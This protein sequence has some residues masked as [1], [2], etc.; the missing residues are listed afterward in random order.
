M[1]SFKKLALIGV[2]GL[3]AFSISCTELD[4]GGEFNPPFSVSAN[5]AQLSGTIIANEGATITAVTVTADGK[6]VQFNPALTVGGASIPLAGVEVNG[7]CKATGATTKKSFKI[8]V[9]VAFSEGEDIEGEGTTTVDCS[10]DA[11]PVDPDLIKKTVVLSRAGTSYADIDGE[12]K[13]YGQNDVAGSDAIMKS[14]D[15]VAYY[16]A[17]VSNTIYTL[18]GF[19][20]EETGETG[21][22]ALK[23]RYAALVDKPTGLIAPIPAVGVSLISSANKLSDLSGFMTEANINAIMADGDTEIAI[24]AVNSGFLV[25]TSDKKYV[26]VIV[27]AGGTAET[28]TLGTTGW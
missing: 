1:F 28:V 17:G 7:I 3:T 18:G 23:A 26:A 15:L 19:I 5:D 10:N 21:L 2:A 16:K 22:D 20:V 13:T 6:A 11:P 14:I 8:V 4:E 12:T 27:K 25:F 24:P 9:T